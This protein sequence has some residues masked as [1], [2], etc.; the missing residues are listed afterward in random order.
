V[1]TKAI[2]YWMAT[3]ILVFTMGSGGAAELAR[4]PGDVAGLARLGDYP[5]VINIALRGLLIAR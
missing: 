4:L 2:A 5:R 1:K 3:A